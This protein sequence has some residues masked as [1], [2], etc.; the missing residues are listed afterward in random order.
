ML[1]YYIVVSY[2]EAFLLRY[3]F[4]RLGMSLK[5]SQYDYAVIGGG[6]GGLGSARRASGVYGAKTVVIESKRI[7][8]TCVNV[9]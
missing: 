1:R 8:G 4:L 7:G 2:E 6:S 5:P 3:P 9:G